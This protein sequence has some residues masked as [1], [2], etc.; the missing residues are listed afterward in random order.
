MQVNPLRSAGKPSSLMMVIVQVRFGASSDSDDVDVWF[1]CAKV[2]S[3]G[4][5]A[6]PV[7]SRIVINI[8][9]FISVL[10]S[11]QALVLHPKPCQ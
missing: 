5:V 7:R 4:A 10:V 8:S 3:C 6:H 2:R 9:C 1:L 11:A